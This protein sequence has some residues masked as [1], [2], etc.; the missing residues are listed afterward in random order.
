MNKADKIIEDHI[1]ESIKLYN[2]EIE[3]GIDEMIA[4]IEEF[5]SLIKEFNFEANPY[6]LVIV[7]DLL[8]LQVPKM[9]PRQKDRFFTIAKISEHSY[10]NLIFIVKTQIQAI[11]FYDELLCREDLFDVR[12]EMS[13]SR[14]YILDVILDDDVQRFGKV[15]VRMIDSDI[16]EVEYSISSVVVNSEYIKISDKN[17][18]IFYRV[19][20]NDD[21]EKLDFLIKTATKQRCPIKDFHRTLETV[22]SRL[23]DRSIRIT[24]ITD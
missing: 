24:P 9:H 8:K 23:K 14:R 13:K 6:R 11:N 20:S 12:F 18:Q 5:H 15:R 21:Y 3:S 19:S 10:E 17:S 2:T 22:K 1:I 16:V 7:D 4:K